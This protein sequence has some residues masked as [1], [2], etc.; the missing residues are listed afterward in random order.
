MES[1]EH[2]KMEKKWRVLS[3]LPL[4]KIG[5][6]L[7]L[8][9]WRKCRVLSTIPWRKWRVLST[10]LWRDWRTWRILENMEIIGEC[11]ALYRGEIGEH[12]EY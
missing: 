2:L 9:P 4:E 10:I 7:A 6:C 5:E 8:K 11:L 3:T 1:V 12:G